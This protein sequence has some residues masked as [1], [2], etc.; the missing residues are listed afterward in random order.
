MKWELGL[1]WTLTTL[2]TTFQYNKLYTTVTGISSEGSSDED[3]GSEDNDSDEKSDTE[4]NG[5][6]SSHTIN[7]DSAK[8]SQSNADSAKLSKTNADCGKLSK[9]N[10]DSTKLSK[11]DFGDTTIVTKPE[12]DD[13]SELKTSTT[14]LKRDIDLEEDSEN[15]SPHKRLK[16]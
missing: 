16:K 14:E 1:F 3:C 8:L 13:C 12:V 11:T 15:R 4:E 2:I 5:A 9:N 6:S 7:A 10:A